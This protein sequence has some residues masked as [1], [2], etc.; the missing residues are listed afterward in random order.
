MSQLARKPVLTAR[1]SEVLTLV[2]AGH[3]NKHIARTLGI[4]PKTVEK[5]LRD[6]YRRLGVQCR[7]A[8][9]VR[10]QQLGLLRAHLRGNTD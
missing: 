3:T 2:A 1:Q 8:A 9:V 4:S 5:H 6:V 10:G 7:V